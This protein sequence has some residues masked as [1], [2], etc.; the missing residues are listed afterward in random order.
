MMRILSFLPVLALLA[1]CQSEQEVKRQQYVSE[2]LEVYKKHCSNCHQP[3]GKG[4]A[5]LYPPL[6]D[7][8]YLTAANRNAV[9]CGIRYGFHAPLTVN[10]QVYR[11]SMPANPQLKPLDVA[12]LMTFLSSKFGKDPAITE[13]AD[14]EKALADC[15]QP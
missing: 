13:V 10:G 1:S 3:D 7:S 15:R 2:G 6:A 11:Q 9:L 8:D 5:K 4:M 14:V 12:V